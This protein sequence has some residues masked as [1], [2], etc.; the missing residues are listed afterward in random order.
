MSASDQT[1]VPSL[2]R[3]DYCGVWHTYSEQMCRDMTLRSATQKANCAQCQAA[4]RADERAKYECLCVKRERAAFVE[5]RQLAARMNTSQG[6]TTV[7]K[8]KM[9]KA[10]AARRYPLP[11]EE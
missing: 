1:I 10:Q 8:Y 6:I 3:C 7:C 9:A 5:G 2:C 11:K 4:I